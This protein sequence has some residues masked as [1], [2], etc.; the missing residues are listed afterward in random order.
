M[1]DY[2]ELDRKFTDRSRLKREREL[3][4]KIRK[5]DWWQE[6]IRAGICHYCE[7]KFDCDALT[8]DHIVPLARGGSSTKVNLV[9][10]CQNCNQKK[11]LKTPV[12]EILDSLKLSK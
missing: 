9:P 2:I 6:K 12:E 11:K 8:M 1:G 5:S 7:A 3:A 10:A 4:K